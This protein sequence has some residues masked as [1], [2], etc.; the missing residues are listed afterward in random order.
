MSRLPPDTSELIPAP[1]AAPVSQPVSAPGPAPVVNAIPALWYAPPPQHFDTHWPRWAK[2]LFAFAALILAYLF[3]DRPATLWALSRPIVLHGGLKFE[4]IMLMQYG[5]WFCSVLVI[6]A[7]ALMDR[8]GRRKAIAIALGCICT[9]LLTYLLKGMIGRTR[10]YVFK[11]GTWK[12]M[13]PAYGFTSAAYQS[14]PSA[15]T[16][17]AF[18]LSAGLAWFYPNARALFYALALHVAFQRVLHLA[19]FASDTIAGMILAVT[20]VRSVLWCNL[21]G[22]FIAALPVEWQQWIFTDNRTAADYR[23]AE[24]FHRE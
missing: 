21:P 23:A 3:L 15:H 17:G 5:Q 2:Y 18:A 7:V 11:N 1:P 22:K 20:M 14:F 16:T 9:V 13:G 6:I 4:F 24:Q 10:P 12:F 19:H 8:H